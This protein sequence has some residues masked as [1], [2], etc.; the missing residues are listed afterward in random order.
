MRI[1]HHAHF[2]ADPVVWAMGQSVPM[3]NLTPEGDKGWLDLGNGTFFSDMNPVNELSMPPP[4]IQVW[5]PE[6]DPNLSQ[7]FQILETIQLEEK[8]RPLCHNPVPRVKEFAESILDELIEAKILPGREVF[9]S[10]F[11]Q[12]PRLEYHDRIATA[13]CDYL[14]TTPSLRYTSTLRRERKD[15]DP[16]EDF[17]F[18]TRSGHCE[19][20]ASALALLLRSQGI[21][22]VLM[23]GFKGCDK[24]DEPGKYVVR[25]AHAHAWVAALIQHYQSRGFGRHPLS[26]WRSL[27]PEP[28]YDTVGAEKNQRSDSLLS[29]LQSRF[30]T[31]IANFNAEDR[32]RALAELA[33]RF[34]RTDT[35]AGIAAV[36]VAVLLACAWLRRRRSR[37]ID[38][39]SPNSPQNVWF[40]RLV[41]AVRVYGF[42][43]Q[44]GETP[45]EFAKRMRRT[46]RSRPAT[47][48]VA[49]V[50]VSWAEAYYET[51][52]G[53]VPLEPSRLVELES[54]LAELTRALSVAGA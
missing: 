1:N 25:E 42:N 36:V 14:A 26:C 8:L 47:R 6:K 29:W 48:D 15:V 46:L 7:P 5:R 52:F 27:D 32:R 13:F 41:S 31:Y 21:P 44:T 18:H 22:A 3:A 24:T 37:P 33:D 19:R 43:P 23:L 2:L 35:L 17:L 50:P 39:V 16:V 11:T 34:T 45:L 28:V 30:R 51:R 10:P 53:D 38:R 54:R 40:N 49:N 9:I 4:Y 12:R 20:F